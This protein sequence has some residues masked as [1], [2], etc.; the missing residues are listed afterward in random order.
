MVSVRGMLM[1]SD[2]TSKLAMTRLESNSPTS[3]ANEIESFIVYSL[4]VIGF[5]NLSLKFANL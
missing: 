3:L 1:K 4:V 5:S 2:F